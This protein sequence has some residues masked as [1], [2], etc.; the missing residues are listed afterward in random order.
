M[1]TEPTLQEPAIDWSTTPCYLLVCC[2]QRATRTTCR[3]YL[4]RQDALAFARQSVAA[5]NISGVSVFAYHEDPNRFEIIYESVYSHADRT[6]ILSVTPDSPEPVLE[7]E[8]QHALRAFRSRLPGL[9]EKSE[10]P[11]P[12][13]VESTLR[14]Y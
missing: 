12:L 1:N 2:N 3:V 14:K 9:Q 8:W 5:G 10:Y 4:E 11:L 6:W 13:V 7:P